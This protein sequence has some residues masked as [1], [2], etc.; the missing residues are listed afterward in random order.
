MVPTN[1]LYVKNIFIFVW[2][3][4]ILSHLFLRCSE[5][6]NLLTSMILFYTI[7]YCIHNCHNTVSYSSSTERKQNW[8]SITQSGYLSDQSSLKPPTIRIKMDV[9]N[10]EWTRWKN[11]VYIDRWNNL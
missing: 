6:I 7:S 8:S 5:S 4:L 1:M 2:N 3:D 9:M 11:E 10:P